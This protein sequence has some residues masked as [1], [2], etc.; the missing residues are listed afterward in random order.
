MKGGVE[1]RHAGI[2]VL[3]KIGI[4]DIPRISLEVRYTLDRR[5]KPYMA[6]KW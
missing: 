3:M 6:S 4:G 2:W 5:D 1:S